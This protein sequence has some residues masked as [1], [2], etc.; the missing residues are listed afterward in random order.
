ML[1]HRKR[2]I[3]NLISVMNRRGGIVVPV[4]I[5]VVL[6]HLLFIT[7]VD[8]FH[9]GGVG[10][11]DGCHVMHKSQGTS[12]NW[13]LPGTDPSSVCLTC[14]A[15]IGSA[16]SYHIASPDGSAMTPGGD[17]Y[18]LN[19]DFFWAGGSSEGSSHGH[20]IVAQDNGFAADSVLIKAP[21]G[22][23]NSDDLGCTSCHDPHGK[24]NSGVPISGSGSYGDVPASG[25]ELGNYR[26]LGGTGY[27]G[28]EHVQGYSFDYP[29]PVARQ[30]S[31]IQYGE[32]DSSHVDYGAGMSEWCA[33]CHV[34]IL[35]S[36]HKS[37]SPSFEHPIGSNG[38]LEGAE[39]D[40]YNSYIKTGDFSGDRTTAYLSLVP[41]ERGVADS[42]L[43][44]PTSTM[45][46]DSNSRI[47]CLT[48]HR[49]H[50]SA[51]DN[52]GRWDFSAELVADSHPAAG[53]IGATGNDLMYSYYGRD[54]ITEFGTQQRSLCEKCHDVPR[55]GYPPGW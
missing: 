28:G 34:S 53:D 42:T 21:G 32:T 19:K 3:H 44:D 10:N 29:A 14:H 27:D 49:A 4:F 43:L 22:S 25:T 8:A 48:C 39:M 20:N 13:L 7:A 12:S 52:I 54:M 47:S 5:T 41:F 6:V 15:G 45:G 31:A 18:W 33:N 50:A 37:V 23:Y 51:F 46:P 11:C 26:L 40:R 35:I 38:Y 16:T 55:G 30:N 24:I 9:D 1:F 2:A 17:F 36:E